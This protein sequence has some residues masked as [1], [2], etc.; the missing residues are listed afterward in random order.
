MYTDKS[1]IAHS[2]SSFFF[3]QYY[4]FNFHPDYC[5]YISYI[6][7]NLCI[8]V[9]AFLINSPVMGEQTV[10]K[11][12]LLPMTFWYTFI[13]RALWEVLWTINRSLNVWV[14]IRLVGLSKTDCF[15]KCLHQSMLPSCRWVSRAPQLCPRVALPNFRLSLPTYSV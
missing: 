12:L 5:L 13:Q 10:S 7:S 14:Y 8:V 15:A 2:T 4:F 3:I 1:F 6:T 9:Y 11:S